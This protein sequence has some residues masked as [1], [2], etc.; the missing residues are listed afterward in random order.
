M[1][2]EFSRL[3]KALEAKRILGMVAIEWPRYSPDLNPL[4]FSLWS[5]IERRAR[6][7]VGRKVVSQKQYK[8]VLRETA[9]K[10]PVTI[11]RKA[12]ESMKARIEAV[13]RAKGAHVPRD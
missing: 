6:Q 3:N 7:S 11:V 1:D 4:D 12:V 2:R 13:Y 8:R 10:L 5:E 9:L